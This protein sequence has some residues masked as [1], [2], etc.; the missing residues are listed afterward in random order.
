VHLKIS[1][2]HDEILHQGFDT[3]ASQGW[4]TIDGNFAFCKRHLG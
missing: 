2:E 4:M 3:K 1:V